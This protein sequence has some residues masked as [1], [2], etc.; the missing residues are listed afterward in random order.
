MAGNTMNMDGQK[1][2]WVYRSCVGNELVTTSALR[3][4]SPWKTGSGGWKAGVVKVGVCE[5][6]G[7]EAKGWK[8]GGREDGRKEVGGREDRSRASV[9]E[10]LADSPTK[11]VS[12]CSGKSPWAMPTTDGP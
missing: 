2:C 1:E 9:Q 8:A 7:R 6:G 4:S 12:S 5:A 11:R 3:V 10:A